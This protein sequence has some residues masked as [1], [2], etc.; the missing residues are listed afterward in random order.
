MKILLNKAH[1]PV[2]VLGPGKRIGIWVQGCSIRCRSCCSLDTWEFADDHGMDVA[3]LVDWCREV[4]AG[5]V[6]GITISGGEPFDQPAALLALLEILDYWRGEG[7]RHMDILIYTGYSERRVKRDFA[8]HLRHIDALIAGPFRENSGKEKSY[9]GS[10][11]QRIVVC[12]ALGA[13]RYGPQSL[14]NWQSGIQVAA[15]S[16]GIWMIGIPRGGDLERLEAGCLQR[17]L[18]FGKPSWRC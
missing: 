17:G 11:N 15:D 12:S 3:S 9:C 13:Q 5:C 10:D 6:D 2:S 4:S 1:Y 8:E 7:G 16:E 14:A 18:A